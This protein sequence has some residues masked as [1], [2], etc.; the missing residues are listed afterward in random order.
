[1]FKEEQKK[2]VQDSYANQNLETIIC[3]FIENEKLDS[4]QL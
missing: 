4:L 1:M 2:A 3:K